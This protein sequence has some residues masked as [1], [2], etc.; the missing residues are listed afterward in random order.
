MSS[1]ETTFNSQ[2]IAKPTT[3]KMGRLRKELNAILAIASRDVILA[4]KSPSAWAFNLIM[5][6]MM[7]GIFGGSL[8]QN[9]SSGLGFDYKQFMMIGM[10]VNTLF[11]VT[12]TRITALVEEREQNLTQEIFVAPISRYSIIVAKII[13]ASFSALTQ[14]IGVFLVGLLMGI[15]FTFADALQIF[16]IAPIVCLIAGSLGVIF[17]GFVSDPKVADMGSAM[18]VMPQMFLSGAMIPINHST[19]VLNFL[20]H[21]MPMTYA[22]DLV[23]AIFYYGTP[24]YEAIVIRSPFENIV[25]LAIF[26]IVFMVIGTF[27][28]TRKGR[29]R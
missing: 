23:R 7:M 8:S 17:I 26:F 28:F 22:I 29:N 6:L 16:A 14:L 9:M 1:V 2:P 5:P 19:G 20:A 27:M 12:V 25:I 24:T 18:L 15:D 10:A 4:V 11:M 21:I 3:Q 13:G